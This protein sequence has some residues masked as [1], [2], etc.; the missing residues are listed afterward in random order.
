MSTV[1]T[2]TELLPLLSV[3]NNAG[4]CLFMVTLWHMLTRTSAEY[5]VVRCN[6]QSFVLK[7]LCGNHYFTKESWFVLVCPETLVRDQYFTVKIVQRNRLIAKIQA[8][9]YVQLTFDQ[10]GCFQN[11]I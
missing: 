7:D 10:N 1:R 5:I 2:I 8:G 11:Q 3:N 6:E 9:K 4:V